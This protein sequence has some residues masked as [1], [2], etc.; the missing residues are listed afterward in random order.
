MPSARA[1]SADLDPHAGT[2]TAESAAWRARTPSSAPS[3]EKPD[4]ESRSFSWREERGVRKTALFRVYSRDALL[5]HVRTTTIQ[6]RGGASGCEID[7][8]ALLEEVPDWV[9]SDIR[10][11]G[12]EPAGGVR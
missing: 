8:D 7:A 3:E 9:L 12:Y 11:E 2:Q 5:Q 6:Q 4:V 10:S 1:L